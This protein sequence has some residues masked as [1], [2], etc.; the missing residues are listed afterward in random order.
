MSLPRTLALACLALTA[1]T[2]AQQTP[3]PAAAAWWRETTA[4]ANDGMEGRD[5]GSEAYERAARY[6]AAQLQA[7]GLRPAGD[8]GTFFQR[9]PMHQ[10]DLDAAHSSAEVEDASGGTA[11]KFGK[12]ALR[13]LQEVTLQPAERLPPDIRAAMTFIGYGLETGPDAAPPAGSDRGKVLVYFAGAPSNLS[14]ADRQTFAARRSQR[15]AGSG[16]AAVIAIPNPSDIEPF[17]WPAAYARSVTLSETPVAASTIPS[18]RVSADGAATL[19][20]RSGHDVASILGDG[21]RGASLPSF[22]LHANLHLHLETTS[23]AISSPNILAILPGSDPALSAEYV[24]LSAH[25]DGYGFGTPVLGD[26]LYN[27]ALDDAA[28]V[29][30]LLEL[31]R[32]EAALP[33]AA[34]PRRSLLLCIFTGEEKGLLGS[35]WFTR[36]PTVPIPHIV[37]DLNLDQLRPIFPLKILTMEGIADSTLGDTA[38]TLAGRYGIELRPDLEP[39][40]NLFRRADNINFVRVGVPIASFI[41]GYNRGTPE[42]ATYRDWYARRYHKPQ[43]DLSTPIDWNAAVTFN[44]FFRDLA[45]AV[46]DAPTRPSWSP[47]SSYAPTKTAPGSEP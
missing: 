20:S 46:G 16:A 1:S 28:Y 31:A 21:A 22:P 26:R 35:A 23:K 39:E 10:T 17:H 11:G 9:V 6:V 43:D 47:A 42:E 18:L 14:P 7:A 3:T 45:R 25:L 24:A 13:L 27:G 38:R 40:R 36:H 29:A 2:P 15:L 41:F 37:T 5:T 30:T 34:R 4:L 33:P 44:R 19:F 8:G 12:V 32:T